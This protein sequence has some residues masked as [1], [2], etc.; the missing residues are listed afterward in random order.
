M[1]VPRQ[2]FKIVPA[3]EEDAVA[4]A[5]VESIANEEANLARGQKNLSHVIFGPPSEVRHNFRAK[6]LVDKMKN[7][8]YARNWKAVVEEDGQEKVV[9]W[10][11]WFFYTE[12]QPIEFK[13]IDWPAG[14]NAKACNEF[15]SALTA[16]RAKHQTGRN[17]GCKSTT[18]SVPAQFDYSYIFLIKKQTCKSSRRCRSTAEKESALVSWR[19]VLPRRAMPA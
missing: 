18:V 11:N 9:G 1:A 13:E 15:I 3:T 7:D 10:A 4:L 8:P 14:T 12:P 16:V 19:S 17:F 5:Q 6:G 2:E